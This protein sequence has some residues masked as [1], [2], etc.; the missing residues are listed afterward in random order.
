[1]FR[2]LIL[3]ARCNLASTSLLWRGRSAYQKASFGC[4]ESGTR[5]GVLS[6][7]GSPRG[8]ESF[9]VMTDL[10]AYEFVERSTVLSPFHSSPLV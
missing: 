3:E 2:A 8:Y 1:M 9:P 7:S 4:V 5:Y 10:A 6:V